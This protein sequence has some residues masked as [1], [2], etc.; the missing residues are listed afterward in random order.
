MKERIISIDIL[1]GLTI[2]FMIP[3]H[4]FIKWMDWTPRD[5]GIF[6]EITVF[7]SILTAPFFLIISGMG[8]HYFINKKINENISKSNIFSE[9]LKRSLFIFGVST[10]LQ[11]LFGFIFNTESTNII[12]WSV[13]QVIGFSMIL[14]FSFPFLKQNLRIVLYISVIILLFFLDNIIS[15]F[16]LNYLS[17]LN[18]GV[19]EFIPWV[20]FFIFGLFFG[21]TI[22]NWPG[23]QF[24][25]KLII[26][27]IIGIMSYL[28]FFMRI[29]LPFHYYSTYFFAFFM[30]MV[31]IFIILFCLCYYFFDRKGK[32]IYI[33]KSIIRWG[34]LAFSIYYIHFGVIGIG[35]IV[36]P[37]IIN[38]IYT[39]GFLI[40]QFIIFLVIFFISLE[41]FIR[42]WQRY[43]FFLGIEW[44][45]N[46]ISKKSLFSEEDSK[47][48]N[49]VKYPQEN[50]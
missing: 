5:Y 8:Y 21:S 36:F 17:I 29:L 26:C 3:F 42:I 24:S 7:L 22:S 47:R 11:I 34:K 14:F 9:V 41:M 19:F 43:N 13:F 32:D 48:L 4:F 35:I 39:S 49:V 46:K 25:I 44:F 38:E 15:V 31:G 45:M 2:I 6:K 10:L 23:E 40:Y 50:I 1:R 28:T 37:L 30:L 18:E 27:I 16:K 12:Y 33:Q 20:N